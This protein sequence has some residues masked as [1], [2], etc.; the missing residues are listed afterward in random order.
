MYNFLMS[1]HIAHRFVIH[2][3]IGDR[4]ETIALHFEGVCVCVTMLNMCSSVLPLSWP[5]QLLQ[6][7]HLHGAH[8]GASEWGRVG[9]ETETEQ[10]NH[11]TITLIER[12]NMRV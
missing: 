2:M 6:R 5:C 1:D 4:R 8:D 3:Y 7:S 12:I 10:P 9:G 11:L